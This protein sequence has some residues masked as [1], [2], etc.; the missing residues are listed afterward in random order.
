MIQHIEIASSTIFRIIF[1]ILVLSFLYFI[2]DILIILF[3]S[4]IIASA[5]EPF[6]HWG[7]KYKVPRPVSV[8]FIYLL[9]LGI[10]ALTI[11][12]LIP[13][14]TEQVR[15]LVRELPFII[16]K[17]S[18]YIETLKDLSV[19]YQLNTNPD[20]FLQTM[21][22]RLGQ[23]SS[24][25]FATT[26]GIISGF[27]AALLVFVISFY[28]AIEEG[29]I[30]KFVRAIIPDKHEPYV[31]NLFERSQQQIGKWLRGQLI[32]ALV[33]GIAVFLGLTILGVRYALVIALISALL[34]IIPYVGPII[35]SVLGIFLAF[36]QAP[37]TGLLV[38][39]LFIIIQQIEN[40]IL[41]PKI[42]GKAVGLHPV[43]VIMVLLVGAKMGGVIG[44][45]LAVPLASVV[46][47]FLEDLMGSA[48]TVATP[49]SDSNSEERN[50]A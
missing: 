31:M 4:I 2:R 9:F 18:S 13:P 12:L 33:V 3:T 10:I 29:G 1:I 43:V 11:S 37:L 17:L 15:E 38:L 23:F 25:I 47:V 7:R 36:L 41:Q 22:E 5:V 26:R 49:P 14:L 21:G 27:S 35:A 42:M 44:M 8:V 30:T 48:S 19:K 24:G 40:H 6:V 50:I 45:I 16:E 28:L 39:G 34:E 46:S 20:A 32:L